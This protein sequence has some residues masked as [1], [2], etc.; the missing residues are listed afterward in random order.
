MRRE[1][2]LSAQRAGAGVPFACP[3]LEKRLQLGQLLVQKGRLPQLDV[4]QDFGSVLCASVSLA[5]AQHAPERALRTPNRQN[6][7]VNAWRRVE[8][9]GQT[10]AKRIC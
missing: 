6:A 3:H 7:A 8:G 10:T 4:R 5:H 1:C 9:R 2:R